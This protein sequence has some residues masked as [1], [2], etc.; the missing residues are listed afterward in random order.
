[1]FEAR[2]L[3]CF[4]RKCHTLFEYIICFTLYS[5]TFSPVFQA[6]LRRLFQRCGPCTE[7]LS[8]RRRLRSR[9][10]TTSSLTTRSSSLVSVTHMIQTILIKH[11]VCM[12]SRVKR[13][14]VDGNEIDLTYTSRL[15]NNAR[16]RL[17]EPCH[18]KPFLHRLVS[19][20]M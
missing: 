16:Y 1:M 8:Q 15:E 11:S 3:E 12:T 14:N 5:V 20:L 9:L 18:I 13:P 4:T 6:D 7:K 19:F 17:S 10:S 2:K